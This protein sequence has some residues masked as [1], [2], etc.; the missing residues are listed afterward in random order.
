MMNIVFDL[1][2][3]VFFWDPHRFVGE[4]F[5]DTE[6]Q[7]RVLD[8]IY[9]HRDW[10]ELD[11][12]T[13]DREEAIRRGAE[14][15]G[16]AEAEISKMM[17]KV[18]EALTLNQEM[19]DLITWIKNSTEHKLYVLSN[20][21]VASIDYLEKKYPIWDLFD[22]KVISCRIHMVKPE[23]GI[24]QYLLDAFDLDASETIFIDDLPENVESAA[25]F[26]IKTIQFESPAQFVT[27]LAQY[28]QL[29]FLKEGKLL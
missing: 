20:M 22:G 8:K 16:L 7:K 14:R 26:G 12:G 29:S 6:I 15:T 10:A 11:R 3:V 19:I 13:L 2:N 24:Y 27:E 28:I 5:K 25:K 4:V 9:H 21:H 17:Y 1:G 23:P 18:P